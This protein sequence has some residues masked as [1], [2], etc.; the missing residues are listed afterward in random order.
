MRPNIPAKPCP[1]GPVHKNSL[2]RLSASKFLMDLSGNTN[3]CSTKSL[4]CGIILIAL[5]PR[6][7]LFRQ[8]S[9]SREGHD[10]INTTERKNFSVSVKWHTTNFSLQLPNTLRTNDANEEPLPHIY[11][12]CVGGCVCERENPGTRALLHSKEPTLKTRT[13]PNPKESAERQQRLPL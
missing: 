1:T 4:C 7:N 3:I 2:P 13:V 12:L 10:G 11:P 9:P 8:I 6:I 5:T